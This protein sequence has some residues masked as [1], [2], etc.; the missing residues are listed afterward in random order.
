LCIFTFLM[1]IEALDTLLLLT[2]VFGLLL[3]LGVVYLWANVIAVYKRLRRIALRW[4]KPDFGIVSLILFVI[5]LLFLSGSLLSYAFYI[6]D[7]GRVP[8]AEKWLYEFIGL[9]TILFFSGLIYLALKLLYIQVVSE[10]GIYKIYFSHRKFVFQ[11]DLLPWSDIYD[12]YMHKDEFFSKVSFI[13]RD[14]GMHVIQVPTYLTKVLAF[15]C[16]EF[17]AWGAAGGRGEWLLLNGP[18]LES[19]ISGARLRKSLHLSPRPPLGSS[20][21]I[22]NCPTQPRHFSAPGTRPA[23]LI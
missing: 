10:E 5:M 3:A 19:G 11:V 13:M 18:A 21:T 8:G 15:V 9:S 2:K 20:L 17:W 6:R 4:E 7:A 14:R 1:G 22:P 23:S 12:Y 16:A